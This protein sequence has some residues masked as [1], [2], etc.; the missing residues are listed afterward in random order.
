MKCLAGKRKKVIR[1]VDNGSR[2]CVDP[3]DRLHLALAYLDTVDDMLARRHDL[4][5]VPECAEL[6]RFQIG[7]RP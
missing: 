5:G 6:P 3:A 2:D 1:L 4:D 7:I